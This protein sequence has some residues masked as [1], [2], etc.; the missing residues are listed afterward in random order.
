LHNT[1]LATVS[2]NAF[3]R[4]GKENRDSFASLNKIMLSFG[5]LLIVFAQVCA[6]AAAMSVTANISVLTDCS[7]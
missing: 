3:Q 1:S 2:R 6:A 7:S 5:V 4:R